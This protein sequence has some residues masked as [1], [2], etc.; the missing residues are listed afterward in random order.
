MGLGNLGG[1]LCFQPGGGASKRVNK[2]E[3]QEKRKAIQPAT[4]SVN[5]RPENTE[6]VIKDSSVNEFSKKPDN[7][8]KKRG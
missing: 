6:P 4:D 1:I 3:K 7:K 5:Y 2:N 8:K